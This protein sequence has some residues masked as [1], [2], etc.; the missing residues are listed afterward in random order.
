MRLL[1]I[2][3]A[4]GKKPGQK[5]IGTWKMEPLT[6]STL[7]ALT[8]PAIETSFYD[9][10]LELLPDLSDI[11]AA[12]IVVET[13][14]AKRSYQLSDRLRAQGIKVIL[15]GYHVM[16][17]PT[18]ARAAADSIVIGN[19]ETIWQTVMEDLLAD[20]L[21][22]EYTG[23]PAF[24]SVRPD[25]SIYRGKKYLPVG[26]VETGR[27]CI[28]DCEFCAI[29]SAYHGRYHRR[30]IEDI[31]SDISQHQSRYFFL[32]DD[33]LFADREH[34][35][36]LFRRLRDRQIKWAGQG[37]LM[38]GRDPELLQAMKESGCE[39][40]LI[41]FESLNDD[42]L[43]Q[44]GKLHHLRKDR[45]DLVRAI[46]RAGIHIYATFVFGY[47]QDD[48]QTVAEAL[49]FCQKHR[50]YTAAFNH[51]LPFPGTALYDRLK[52]T[53]RLLFDKWWL[54]D[55]YHY[56]ELAFRPK[57]TTPEALARACYEARKQFNTLP[58]LWRRFW[59]VAKRSSPML[60]LLFW[61]MNGSIGSEVSQKMNVPIGENLD[62]LPK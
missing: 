53:E 22:P 32:V 61:V 46:H 43:T 52:Q 10:R 56:G 3:P 33:N 11:D 47:D 18:E 12:A 14:T 42:N 39:I 36:A 31:L 16:L 23:Q 62:E 13:Y 29:T 58:W 30:P 21:R 24:S 54:A 38:I 48:E 45:D 9:D 34:A 59:Q 60:W 28:H 17:A 37:T 51:L 49:A 57:K 27:G 1:F 6:I 7:K 8:P 4:I 55:G 25:R 2:L 20:R 5:Y 35:L 19:A 41:G 15:G 40:L 44:M 50:I 26:L